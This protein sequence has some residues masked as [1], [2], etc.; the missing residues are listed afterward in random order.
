MRRDKEGV[1]MSTKAQQRG[2]RLSRRAFL[3]SAGS[4]AVLASTATLGKDVEAA[5][6]SRLPSR[7]DTTVDV[8]VVGAGGAGL[9]AAIGAHARRKGDVLVIDK[10]PTLLASTS[11]ICGG[12][13]SAAG[14]K[15]QRTEGMVDTPELFYQEMIRVGGGKN[16]PDLVRV[17]VNNAADTVDWFGD[18]GMKFF[19]RGYPGFTVNRQHSNVAATGRE[20]IEMMHRELERRGVPIWLDTRAVRLV[21]DGNPLEVLG[22]EV[23]REG[24]PTFIRVRRGVVLATGGF[25]GSKEMIDRLMVPFK[26]AIVAAAPSS[27]GDGFLMATEIGATVTHLGYGAVYAYGF[28]TDPESRR[29]LVHRGYEVASAYGGIIVNALGKRF[30]KEETT[31]TGVALVQVNQPDQTLFVI[32]DAPMLESFAAMKMPGVIGWNHARVAREIEEQKH[33]ITTADTLGELARKTGIPAEAL[34]KTVRD[35]N[36]HVETGVDPEF[37]RAKANLRARIATPPFVAFKGRPVALVSTG[38]LK[39]NR[40]FR[41][42]DAYLKPIKHLYAAGEVVGGLHG[43]EY[44]GGCGFSSAL[45]FGRLAG[46]NAMALG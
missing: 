24:A 33:F 23:V 8:L 19:F 16:D 26:G 6:A 31:P 27:T 44:L 20:Y 39:V 4:A 17:F 29:G 9:A 40:G 13:V 28:V 2:A 21:V 5:E 12:G 25:A 30:V 7:W 45:T 37:G 34:E 18:R 46:R 41:V 32:G 14:T 36:G 42:L 35:Y 11:A 10:N 38:G 15:V 3:G 1:V 22:V 43:V